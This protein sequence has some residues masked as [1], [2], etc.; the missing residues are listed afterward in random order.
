VVLDLAPTGGGRHALNARVEAFAGERAFR[1][2]VRPHTSYLS[3]HDPRI[4]IGFGPA[5]QIDRLIVK[6]TDGAVGEWKS[7]PVRKHL[8]LRQGAEAPEVIQGAAFTR[9]SK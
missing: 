3:S 4:H 7:V 2:E 6:W 8:R 1:R 9:G 5:D